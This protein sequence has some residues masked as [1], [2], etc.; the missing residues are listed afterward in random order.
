MQGW[1]PFIKMG[2]RK[3]IDNY[4]PISILTVASR[5]LEGAVEIQLLSHLGKGR[6]IIFLEGGG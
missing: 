2:I 4:R 1:F 3:C 6:T 5:I